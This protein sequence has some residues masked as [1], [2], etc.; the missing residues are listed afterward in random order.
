MINLK[1]EMETPV[2]I[3][4]GIG[5]YWFPC[6]ANRFAT[7]EVFVGWGLSS[8]SNE[9]QVSGGMLAMSPDNGATWPLKYQVAR[10]PLLNFRRRDGALGGT[11][12]QGVPASASQS[13]RARFG[14]VTLSEG[15]RRYTFEPDCVFVEGFPRDLA[16]SP[17]EGKWSRE[18][19]LGIAMNAGCARLGDTLLAVPYVRYAGAEKTAVVTIES[20]DEGRTWRYVSE[21]FAPD[22]LPDMAEGATEADLTQLANGDLLCVARTG[23]C[24]QPT[25]QLVQAR[26]SDGGRT[27]SPARRISPFSVYPCLRRLDNGVLALAAGRPGLFLWLCEDCMGEEWS[28]FDIAAHHNGAMDE[29]HRIGDAFY[30]E[31]RAEMGQTTAYT[32]IVPLDG[33]RLLYIYDRTPFGWSPVPAD[34]PERSRIYAMP[35]TISREEA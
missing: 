24:V 2:V 12:F 33:G 29:K 19:P 30:G 1:V 16:R 10:G 11:Y 14:Y 6:S 15:G 13:R 9:I 5:H 28:Q 4:E 18:W 22:A 35:M 20:Q 17:H 27:W 25:Q 34:S 32:Q 21:I 26:S 3:G 7:G 31:S 23:G 8:D